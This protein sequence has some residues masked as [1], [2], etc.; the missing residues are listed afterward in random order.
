LN[1]FEIAEKLEE[2]LGR[3]YTVIASPDHPEL[4]SGPDVLVG[5]RGRITAIFRIARSTPRRLLEAR[6]VATRLALPAG[7]TLLAIVELDAE[8]PRDLVQNG[9]D[10]A[11]SD[12]AE[13]DVVRVC[14]KGGTERRHLDDLRRIQHQHAIFYSTVLQIAEFRQRHQPDAT[15]AR[16]IIGNL[17]RRTPVVD[18]G[19]LAAGTARAFA[20]GTSRRKRTESLRA[21]VRQTTVAALPRSQSRS[22]TPRLRPLW[23][24][25]L[26]TDFVLDTGVPYPRPFQPRVLLVERWPSARFDPQKP[27]RG[28]AFSGWLMAIPTTADEIESLVDRA[29]E[30]TAKRLHA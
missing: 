13:R 7:A 11:V 19:S 10:L 28:A 21:T 2:R 14:T 3:D 17:R 8:P 24:E 23:S 12:R 20:E 30:I 25:A 1:R 27:V 6:V 5:G 29:L 15:S 18:E 26:S 22:I 4:I 9:F 16:E